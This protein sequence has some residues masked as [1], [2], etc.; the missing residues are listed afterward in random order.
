LSWEAEKNIWFIP[1]IKYVFYEQPES[2]VKP[3]DDLYLN[4]TVFFKF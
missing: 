1:N 4:I 3:S 2:G